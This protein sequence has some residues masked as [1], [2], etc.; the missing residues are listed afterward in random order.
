ME[1]R[2][3]AT[4]LHG[5]ER[6]GGEAAGRLQASNSVLFC[7]INVNKPKGLKVAKEERRLIGLMVD[8]LDG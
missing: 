1:V 3:P 6:V 2:A 7:Y 8:M 4:V 5:A